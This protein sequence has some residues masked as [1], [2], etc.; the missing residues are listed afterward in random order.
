MSI[1]NDIRTALM[2]MVVPNPNTAPTP[3]PDGVQPSYFRNATSVA[4]DPTS[5]NYLRLNPVVGNTD[6][7]KLVLPG[8]IDEGTLPRIEVAVVAADAENPTLKGRG[9]RV[10][11]GMVMV[12]VVWPLESGVDSVGQITD[13]ASQIAGRFYAGPYGATRRPRL[14]GGIGLEIVG[15]AS[16]RAVERIRSTLN[17]PIVIPYRAS[18]DD[19]TSGASALDK[20]EGGA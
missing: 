6:H 11:E 3:L 13:A 14:V 12:N 9:L 5:T 19:G 1:T 10:E 4:R 18:W 20:S 2:A 17:L 8:V 16:I 15:A 7:I